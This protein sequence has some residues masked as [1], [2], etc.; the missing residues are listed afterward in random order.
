MPTFEDA[1]NGMNRRQIEELVEKAQRRLASC[2]LCGGDGAYSCRVTS[3]LGRPNSVT[4]SL[5]LCPA[6]VERNR[7]PVGRSD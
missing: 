3:R 6:C 5:Q 4:F 2:V 1:L 7:Q